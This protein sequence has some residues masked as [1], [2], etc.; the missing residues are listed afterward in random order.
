MATLFQRKGS[1][2][3][4]LNYRNRN[5]RLIQL[6]T[7]CRADVTADVRRAKVM[8]AEKTLA[9]LK[10]G[11]AP[12]KRTGWVWVPD[13]LQLHCSGTTLERYL[14]CWTAIGIFL[15]EKNI[16]SPAHLLREH[17]FDF[18][19]WR[20]TP[21][22]R[23]GVY[24]ARL[25]TALLELKILRL[26]MQEAVR[27]GLAQ[28]NPCVS[29][30]IAKAK[31]KVKPELTAEDCELIRQKIGTVTDQVKREMFAN[32]FEI[33]RYQGCRLSETRL[34][35]QTDVDL[36]AG[37]IR[38]YQKGSREF[39]TALHPKLVPLFKRL[40]QE[41]RTST[42]TPPPKSGRQWASTAWWKFLDAHGFTSRG[43]CFH[44]TRV[45]VVTELARANVP[46]A[47]AQAFVGHASTIV[48]RIYQR[49]RPADLED[50][51]KVVGS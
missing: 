1:P 33:A 11:H 28:G 16:E 41:G 18:V 32:S 9:E 21:A 35:P 12:R 45:T 43:I 26:I 7:R 17:C 49:L 50:C 23:S 46:E 8:Q 3:L 39:T 15:D 44:T 20:Q 14:G 42:W 51:T 37:T 27:R 5:G 34:N 29:L 48:H 38:F 47:K 22:K 24:T 31:P 36:D 2:Y 13:F 19:R 40:R 30:G 6:S 4:W 10:D 25:N